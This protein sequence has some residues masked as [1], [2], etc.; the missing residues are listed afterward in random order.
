MKR[1]KTK[2]QD[3]EVLCEYITYIFINI[4]ESIS[5]YIRIWHTMIQFWKQ[6]TGKYDSYL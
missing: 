4:F 3:S 6:A 1:S 5:I 2:K